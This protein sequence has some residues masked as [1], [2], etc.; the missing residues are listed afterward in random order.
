[1]KRFVIFFIL[2]IIGFGVLAQQ[3]NIKT[4][5][6]DNQQPIPGVIS[7]RVKTKTDLE[8]RKYK[9]SLE[10]KP[11]LVADSLTSSDYIMSA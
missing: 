5:I 3:K 9:Q 8:D 6:S 4:S 7:K 2:I 10:K 1:M 11:V